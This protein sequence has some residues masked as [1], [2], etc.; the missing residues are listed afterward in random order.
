MSNNYFCFKQFAV[1]QDNTAMKVGTDGVLL[2]AWCSCANARRVLDVGTGTGLIAMMVAQRSE[3]QVTAVEIDSSACIDAVENFGNCPWSD[4]IELF[5]LSVQEFT[6]DCQERFDLIVSNPP[7]FSNSLKAPSAGRALARH[8]D[9]LPV[10]DLFG[11]A[12]RL[13]ADN[14]RLSVIIPADRIDDYDSEAALHGLGP[15]RRAMVR[16]NPNSPFHR[17]MVEYGYG[18]SYSSDEIISIETEEHSVY[19]P[20]YIA[21]TRDF[22]LKF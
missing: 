18:D 3:A 10:S 13:L 16:P 19:S 1:V 2:G 11:C 12:V 8:D 7:F 15:V 20:E 17:A 22:Y 5:N 21:L 4:R 14:G 9:T 6:E